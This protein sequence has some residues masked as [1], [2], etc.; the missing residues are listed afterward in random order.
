MKYVMFQVEDQKI[1]IIFPEQLV[2]AEVAAVVKAVLSNGAKVVSAG[3]ITAMAV[4]ATDGD[5]ETLGLKSDP[6]DANIIN[7]Y[8][9]EHGRDSIMPHIGIMIRLRVAELLMKG[10][11][12]VAD[13]NEG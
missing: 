3:L 7:A 6:A 8:P 11:E 13:N 12:G 4:V 5:S 1:P 9:Y 10:V 2:H